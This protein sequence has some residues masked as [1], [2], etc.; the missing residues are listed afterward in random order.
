MPVEPIGD[1]PPEADQLRIYIEKHLPNILESF[2]QVLHQKFGLNGIR[3]G[4]FTVVPID[5]NPERL[6]CNEEHCSIN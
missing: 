4:G 5:S 2:S 3:V 6:T 1:L